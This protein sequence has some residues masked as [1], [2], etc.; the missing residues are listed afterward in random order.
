MPSFTVFA[1]RRDIVAPGFPHRL[2]RRLCRGDVDFEPQVS[3]FAGWLSQSGEMTTRIYHLLLHV[4]RVQHRFDLEVAEEYLGP[5]SAWLA[6][7]NA[8]CFVNEEMSVRDP[9]GR[10]LLS[11]NLPAGDPQAEV[12]YFP[13]A[14]ERRARSQAL[15]AERG[16]DTL[17]NLPPV[18]CEPELTL[19]TPD[20]AARRCLALAAVA[21]RAETLNDGNAVAVKQIRAALGYDPADLSPSEADFMR[22]PGFLRPV[23]RPDPQTIVN[24]G[25]RYEA[26]ATLMWVLGLQGELLFPSAMVDA[27]PAVQ[28]L[29]DLGGRRLVA[30]AALRPAGE[31]LDQLDL[32]YRLHWALTEARLGRR[33]TYEGVE[34]GVVKERHHVL[35]WLVRFDDADWDQV[36]TPT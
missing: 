2:S 14:L 28:Q 13:Q 36:T 3:G 5:F 7:V 22:E 9:V 34:P 11:F 21:V 24:H 20:E 18:V 8:V 31:I 35:N 23:A 10:T 33:N 27:G 12:P 29:S 17:A 25:W 15:L 19:R 26:A 30:E 1:T 6:H 16:I 4:G 32:T